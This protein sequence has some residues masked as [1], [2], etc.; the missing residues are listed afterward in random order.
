MQLGL[1]PRGS[2]RVISAVADKSPQHEGGSRLATYSR[3]LSLALDCPVCL[4]LGKTSL[5][6]AGHPICLSTA[7]SEGDSMA[8]EVAKTMNKIKTIIES[9]GEQLLN[10]KL[11]TRFGDRLSQTL[12][13]PS[14]Y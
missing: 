8:S 10:S 2:R 3:I 7:N 12:R 6:F 11:Q 5:P 13:L 9:S 14:H 4:L 1:L